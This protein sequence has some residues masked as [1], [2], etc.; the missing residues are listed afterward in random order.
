MHLPQHGLL[1]PVLGDIYLLIELVSQIPILAIEHGA[2]HM[3]TKWGKTQLPS[4]TQACSV[5]DAS[6]QPPRRRATGLELWSRWCPCQ[7]HECTAEP[8]A[9]LLLQ[10]HRHRHALPRPLLAGA[11]ATT[12]F[13]RLQENLSFIIQNP[14][15]G[16]L[17]M[18]EL[19]DLETASKD[20]RKMSEHLHNHVTWMS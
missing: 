17:P 19:L 3:N 15:G 1:L 5:T 9:T 11:A 7:G 18:Q 16:I 12:T 10:G 13:H 20:L 14:Q 6:R 8:A 4:H 2:R